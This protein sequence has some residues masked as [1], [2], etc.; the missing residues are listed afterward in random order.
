MYK[1]NWI[2]FLTLLLV[3][4]QPVMSFG[5][6]PTISSDVVNNQEELPLLKTKSCKALAHQEITISSVDLVV[7]CA[8]KNKS[9]FYSSLESL[10]ISDSCEGTNYLIDFRSVLTTQI[11]PFHFFL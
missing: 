8:S 10:E 3:F 2:P 11:F 7:S 4:L 6:V 9:V 5:H 1:N